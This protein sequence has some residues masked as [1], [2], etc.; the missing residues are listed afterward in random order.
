MVVL[1]NSSQTPDVS[2]QLLLCT[3]VRMEGLKMGQIAHNKIHPS[4]GKYTPEHFS[5]KTQNIH[6]ILSTVGQ[7]IKDTPV[8]VTN[9]N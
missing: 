3:W 9:W 2:S 7:V 5:F 8:I 6:T 4:A 1:S